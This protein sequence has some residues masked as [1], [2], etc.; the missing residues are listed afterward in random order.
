MYRLTISEPAHA[1]LQNI[2]SYIAKNLAAP[3]AASSYADEV[4]KCYGQ[5]K[6]NPL[7]YAYCNDDRL[8][9]E[10]Y[11]KVRI[12]NYVLVFTADESTKTVFIHRLFYGAQDYVNRL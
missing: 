9:Q 2:L 5:L 8:R 10:G 11:R 1:D 12:K 4:K 3:H 7:I 6:S